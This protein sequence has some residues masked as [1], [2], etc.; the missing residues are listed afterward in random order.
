MQVILNNVLKQ[1]H[2]CFTISCSAVSGG[3]VEQGCNNDCRLIS[4]K[5]H[6]A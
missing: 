6:M 1:Q 3:S 2:T 4:S 5:L